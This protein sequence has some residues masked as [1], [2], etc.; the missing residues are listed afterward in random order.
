[1]V[2]EPLDAPE[3]ER[4]LEAARRAIGA[5]RLQADH[6]YH[7]WACFLAE[8]AAQLGTKGLLHGIGVAAWGH[9]LGVLCQAVAESLGSSWP[10]DA[11]RWAERLSRFYIPT[12]YPDAV[13][14]RIPGARY[15]ADDSGEALA[16]AEAMLG[17][18]VGA[19]AELRR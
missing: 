17:A 4:W 16:D 15:D 6:G 18:V 3:Y 5:A 9:D 14:G 10:G 11:S 1:M 2:D 19:W 13:P 8:Q 7:E 12:R